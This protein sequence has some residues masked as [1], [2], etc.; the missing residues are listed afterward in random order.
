ML[1]GLLACSRSEQGPVH[2]PE[3]GMNLIVISLDTLR[4]DHLGC[5]GYGR[6]T[7][8]ALDDL[9]ARSILFEN[10]YSQA[11]M[12]APSHGTI[13]TGRYPSAH[14]LEN[15]RAKSGADGVPE[16]GLDPSLPILAEILGRNGWSS[17]GVAD[18]GPMT[19][20]QGLERGFGT[21][22]SRMTPVG[23][24]IEEGR[25]ALD[26]LR[27]DESPW[28]LFWH[29][30]EIH[31]PYLPSPEWDLWQD[32][33]NPARAAVLEIGG[34]NV[35]QQLRDGTPVQLQMVKDLNAHGVDSDLAR[36]VTDLYDG[37]IA[38]T[39]LHLGL[40]LE[41]LEAAG[42]LDSTILVI[43]S[44][45]GEELG[46]H[47]SLGH[48]AKLFEERL[49]VP[50]IIHLPGDRLAGMK[51]QMRAGLVDVLPTL[52]DLL[53][54][55]APT[56]LDGRSLVDAME[57]RRMERLPVFSEA[58]WRKRKRWS[59]S[60]RSGTGAFGYRVMPGIPRSK[61]GPLFLYDLGTDP[62]THQNLVGEDVD[63]SDEK[64]MR[65]LPLLLS[66]FV[67]RQRRA[68]QARS[69]GAETEV[70]EA[71]RRELENLGYVDDEDG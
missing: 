51:V 27:S 26:A 48:Q 41:E 46:E 39:D 12:T 59:V 34:H 17:A 13:F 19:G 30:Y 69:H 65:H 61:V 62:G 2:R 6:N 40:W 15:L 55:A 38:E 23:K 1:M 35:T 21:W 43:L 16:E 9:A 63:P 68:D 10:V 5:Y 11:D 8:P 7:S 54:V 36:A 24:R 56:G 50:W 28:F 4:A 44:D 14:G 49:R 66:T 33:A 58:R 42:I 25:E 71:T 45:H 52:L 47:G 31:A 37:G 64:R 20:G 22:S 53:G 32:P 18:G 60:V 70:D 57:G 67:D 3:Q 29:T